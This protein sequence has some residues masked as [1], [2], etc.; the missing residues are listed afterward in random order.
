MRKTT[1]RITPENVRELSRCEIF[2]FGSNLAG[3]HHGGAARTAHQKF[4]AEWGVGSGATGQCYAIPTMH[5]GVDAIK[6]YVDEFIE[7]A[8]NH[9]KNRFLVT[10]VGCGIAGFKDEEMAALFRPAQYLPNIS[11]PEDWICCFVTWNEIEERYD[12]PEPEPLPAVVDDEVIRLLCEKYSYEIG[13]GI[14]Y[15][16]PKFRIR[17]VVGDNRCG[18]A[19]FGDFFFDKQG[20]LY[21]WHT[22]D[23]W[24]KQHKQDIVEEVFGDECYRRGYAVPHVFDG[25]CADTL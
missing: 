19:N 7:Y 9:P 23:C 12:R 21:V 17:Y 13:A 20:Q 11:F 8:K 4:G 25:V 1:K 22:D 24:C 15:S 6:P 14:Y 2:V 18:T 3:H 10:R 5:G 16:V